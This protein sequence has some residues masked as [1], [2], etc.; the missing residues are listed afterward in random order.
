M[1]DEP[2]VANAIIFSDGMIREQFTGKISLIGIFDRLSS[3]AFP[4]VARFFVT[5]FVTN[6][7]GSKKPL[8]VSLRI[9]K[10]D[11]GHVACSSTAKL[12]F[13][14]ESPNFSPNEVLQVPMPALANF[15]EPGLY[16]AVIL[17]D[18]ETAGKADLRVDSLS[19]TSQQPGKGAS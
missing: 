11:T 8:S 3:P 6:L 12:Q 16:A 7:R 15:P 13:P 1:Q 18:N 5:A 17:V 4:F 10:T 9:E 19:V 14:E 2:V